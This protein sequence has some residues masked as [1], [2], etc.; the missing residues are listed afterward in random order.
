LAP[1][2][3]EILAPDGKNYVIEYREKAG[4]DMG[5]DADYLIIA[6]DRGGIG[7]QAYPGAAG[8]TYVSQIRMPITLG[9]LGHVSNFPGFGFNVI[10]RS[11]DN[12]TVRIRIHP[13]KAPVI[14][15]L[16]SSRVETIEHTVLETGSTTWEPGE[17]VCVEGSWNFEKVAQTQRAIFEAT[18]GD[19]IPPIRAVWR[20]AGQEIL[21]ER[22]MSV[23][24]QVQLANPKLEAHLATRSV[25]L[26]CVVETLP[27]GSRLRVTGASANETFDLEA[28]VELQSSIGTATKSFQVELSGIVYDYGNEF[29]KRRLRCLTDLSDAGRRYATYEV[30]FDPD[31]LGKVP[32]NRRQEAE[33]YLGVLS[34]LRS[35]EDVTL[36]QRAVPDV[37][38]LVMTSTFRL[39]IVPRDDRV[40]IDPPDK[41]EEPPAPPFDLQRTRLDGR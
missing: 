23:F 21:S 41:I 13:G 16:S 25:T 32:P 14:R 28:E 27:N 26:A 9:G 39:D 22:T 7:D 35:Q 37:E 38:R 6:Q 30:L 12:H 10:N 3:V 8:G 15:L 19:G 31:M 18:Y 20:V 4:W 2:A 17:K 24:T 5:Q 33:T 29:N 34:H 36:F 11:P 1:Q 40:R